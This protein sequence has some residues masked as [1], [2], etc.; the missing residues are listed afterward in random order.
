MTVFFGIIFLPF[1]SFSKAQDWAKDI[2]SGK[3]QM[4]RKWDRKTKVASFSKA[5][6][7]TKCITS[8][9]S[10]DHSPDGLKTKKNAL[11]KQLK[12]SICHFIPEKRRA[13]YIFSF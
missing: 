12:I 6:G 10:K 13:C 2:I 3:C 5:Q 11:S 7:W 9:S 8:T 1:V 4:F